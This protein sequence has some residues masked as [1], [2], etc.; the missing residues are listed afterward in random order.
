MSTF[1]TKT[2]YKPMMKAFNLDSIIE[3]DDTLLE[4]A[5]TIAVAQVKDYLFQLYDTQTIFSKAG[6]ERHAYLVRCCCNIVLKI[7]WERLTVDPSP[8]I[9]KNYNDTLDYLERL[10]DAKIAADLPKRL[11]D[12]SEPLTQTRWGSQPKRSHG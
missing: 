5:E 2:D 11:N 1:I 12:E 6:T 8:T 4:E 3:Q 9:E 7:L 10:A